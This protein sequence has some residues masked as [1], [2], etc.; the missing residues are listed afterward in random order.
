VDRA[1]NGFGNGIQRAQQ[2]L[3][4][5]RCE[6]PGPSC[7]INPAAFAQPALGTIGNTALGIIEGP[8]AVTFNLGLS[9]L[10]SVHEGQTVELRGE[11]QNVLNRINYNNPVNTLAS[12]AT[13]GQITSAQPARI[14]QFGVKY[15]F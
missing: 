6:N 12:A 1:L 7:W 15:V 10:I 13:F 14:L 8:G 3:P 4:N 9:R 5:G 2:I 11:A